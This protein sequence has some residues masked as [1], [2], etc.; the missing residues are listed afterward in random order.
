LQHDEKAQYFGVSLSIGEG[1]IGLGPDRRP[2][3]ANMPEQRIPRH[4]QALFNLGALEFT[5]M[6]H[7]GRIEVDPTKPGGLRTPMDA[8]MTAGF[9]NM[10]SAQ[11]MFPVLS[12]DEMAGHF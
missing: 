11:T 3:P 7:D 6:F 8:D 12:A 1:G 9:A 4:A 5:R 10:L 2:D